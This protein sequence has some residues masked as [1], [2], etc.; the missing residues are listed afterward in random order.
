MK[1]DSDFPLGISV[2]DLNGQGRARQ[3]AM[4]GE[5]AGEKDLAPL[6][7]RRKTSA[8]GV[9]GDGVGVVR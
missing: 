4:P 1:R 7:S 8:A 5:S 6:W 3:P 9:C 2:P